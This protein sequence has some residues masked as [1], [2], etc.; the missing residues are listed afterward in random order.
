MNDNGGMGKKWLP[1]LLTFVFWCLLG[2]GIAFWLLHWLGSGSAVVPDYAKTAG[3]ELRVLRSNSQTLTAALGGRHF[4]VAAAP[5][6]A[7]EQ[8][9]AP[10]AQPID[11]KRFKLGGILAQNPGTDGLVILSVDGKPA[12]L[13]SKGETITD[14]VVLHSL[15]KTT[16][17][18]AADM[19]ASP[20]VTLEIGKDGAIAT[21]AAPSKP[22]TPSL[23]SF[24][25]MGAG[26]EEPQAGG[27]GL[28]QKEKEAIAEMEAEL[29]VIA[30]M[31]EELMQREA[32]AAET[33]PA[34]AEVQELV[35][36][37][38]AA[39]AEAAGSEQAPEA[40]NTPPLLLGQQPPE[41]RPVPSVEVAPEEEQNSL[42]SQLRQA[43]E[44]EKARQASQQ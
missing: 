31:E 5:V 9:T 8:Q 14:G 12:K 28:T 3:Q 42:A 10:V 18:L 24:F 23:E 22:A 32:T 2:A 30:E 15:S 41:Q 11:S 29:A 38:E 4:T 13:F 17:S 34:L 35:K 21:D 16:A 39:R 36:A 6:A 26:N 44:R 25:D 27:V 40:V 43:V 20:E 1:P 37:L 7:P 19:Q 33:A